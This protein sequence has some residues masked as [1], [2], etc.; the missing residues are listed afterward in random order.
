MEEDM[1]YVAMM[2]AVFALGFLLAA[3]LSASALGDWALCRGM[4]EG[5]GDS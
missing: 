3:L 5:A 2:V 1:T 4:G